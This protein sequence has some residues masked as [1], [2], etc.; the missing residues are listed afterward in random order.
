M[1]NS[2]TD[3]EKLSVSDHGKIHKRKIGTHPGSKATP[4]CDDGFSRVSSDIPYFLCTLWG[5]WAAVD[6]ETTQLKKVDWK[7]DK[8]H[9]MCKRK[10]LNFC[11]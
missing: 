11:N 4:M 8:R 9:I 1:S 2:S 7:H 5:E 10:L 3:C 6:R